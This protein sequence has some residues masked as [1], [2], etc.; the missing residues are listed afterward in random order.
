MQFI[1]SLPL[2]L[3]KSEWQI[4]APAVGSLRNDLQAVIEQREQFLAVNV[5]RDFLRASLWIFPNIDEW[6]IPDSI[7][8]HVF[9]LNKA[10]AVFVDANGRATSNVVIVNVIVNV[11]EV[12]QD[13]SAGTVVIWSGEFLTDIATAS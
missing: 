4:T 7:R 1:S 13:L 6:V 9:H 5:R 12:P 8:E 3:E 2:G 11:G 10:D